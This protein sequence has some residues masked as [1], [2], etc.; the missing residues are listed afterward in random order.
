MSHLQTSSTKG[1][2][3]HRARTIEYTPTLI[4]H[5]LNFKERFLKSVSFQMYNEGYCIKFTLCIF[6][7]KELL[8]LVV[9]KY[10]NDFVINE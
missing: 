1:N 4:H 9:M 2:L 5:F 8:K 7:F 10:G 3:N 6:F